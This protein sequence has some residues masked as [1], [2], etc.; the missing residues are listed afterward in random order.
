MHRFDVP[1]MLSPLR[2]RAFEEVALRLTGG[3]PLVPPARLHPVGDS[4]FRSTGEEFL[5]LFRD[6]V[7]LVPEDR[8]LDVGCGIGRMA[9]PLAGYLSSAGSYDGFDVSEIA[10][11]WCQRHYARRHPNFRF[12]HVNVANSS[13]NPTGGVAA[14]EF[15]FPYPSSS[16]DFVFLTSVFTHMMSAG[17]ERYVAEISRVLVPGGRCLATFF[18]LNEESRELIEGGRSTQPFVDVAAPYAI[19]D[20]ASPEHAVAYE[21]TWVRSQLD[22]VGLS[23]RVPPRFGSWCG[24]AEFTSYQDIVI[25][26]RSASSAE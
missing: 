11:R 6:L 16:F 15:S 25:A 26:D 9:R 17:I 21:E 5:T 22:H 23:A 18:L 2:R 19:V 8:V 1:Q 7:D 20:P 10:I 14:E 3:E 13:Y 24:R 12:T 4:D